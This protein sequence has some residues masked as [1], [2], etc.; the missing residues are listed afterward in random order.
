MRLAVSGSHNTGKTTLIEALI[1]AMPEY[2]LVDEPYRLLEDEGVQ[3][4]HTPSLADFELQLDR[5]IESITQ[6]DGN[7]VFDRC[8]ADFLAYC[9]RDHDSPSFQVAQWLPRVRHAMKLLDL[10]VLVPVEQPDRISFSEHA[11]LRRRVDEEI[12]EILLEDR[13]DFASEVLEVTGT[14]RER[15][16]LVLDYLRAAN[17]RR[18]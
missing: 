5:S 7:C 3:F 12:R 10:I 18:V 8:P 2:K 13:W 9:L 15:A 17:D 11:R 1:R 16:D 6:R 4:A 14:V